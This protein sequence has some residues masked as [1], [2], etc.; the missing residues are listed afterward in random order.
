MRIPGRFNGPPDSANGGWT[1]GLLAAALNPDP[2]ATATITLRRPPPLDTDLTIGRTA[3]GGL[4]LTHGETL[5]AEATP[6]A[7]VTDPVPPVDPVAA[8]EAATRYPGSTDH[9]FPTCWVC[10]PGRAARDGLHLT[11]GPLPD[12]RTATPFTAPDDVTPT[13]VWAALDCPGGWSVLTPGRPYVLGRM[14]TTVTAVP[15]PGEQCVVVGTCL[16]TEG[17]KARVNTTLYD[18]ST[19]PLATSTAVWIAL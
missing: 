10:G 5:I 17:R 4:T 7:A 14:T 16:A 6:A 12:G 9:P 13:H 18:S 1:A 8:A 15:R 2:T 3:G 19:T 11:P